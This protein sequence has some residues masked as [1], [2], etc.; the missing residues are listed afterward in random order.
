MAVKQ[1]VGARYVP[2]FA[3]PIEWQA[4]T[5][6]DALTIVLYNNASYTSKVTVPPTVGNPTE[7]TNY[8]ALTGNYNA[9]VEQYRQDIVSYK[10]D[11]DNQL[12]EVNTKIDT[13]ETN[14][15]T[16]LGE[17]NTKI[18]TLETNT[19]TQLGEVN[20]KI[21]TL[22][23][24]IN[25][26][27]SSLLT[28]LTSSFI[29][30]DASGKGDFTSIT[31]AMEASD[32]KVIKIFLM[33]GSYHECLDFTS[34][35]DVTIIGESKNA[36][37]YNDGGKYKYSTITLNQKFYLFNLTIKAF[38]NSTFTPTYDSS[39]VENTFPSYALHIDKLQNDGG[40]TGI[41]ENCVIQSSSGACVGSGTQQNS[42][43]KFID[44]EIN[45]DSPTSY[46]S[47]SPHYDSALLIHNSVPQSTIN[48][49]AYV[50]NCLVTNTTYPSASFRGDLPSSSEFTLH[51][52]NN[53]FELINSLSDGVYYA[54]SSSNL[55]G[56]N[57]NSYE[58]NNSISNHNYTK[59]YSIRLENGQHTF[60]D[61]DFENAKYISVDIRQDSDYQTHGGLTISMDEAKLKNYKNM[62]CMW[63]GYVYETTGACFMTVTLKENQ[64]V[65]TTNST[66]WDTIDLLLT[67]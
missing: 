33:N 3:T 2:K 20:T 18:D 19:D 14:T 67:Y 17:V 22:E 56:A 54:K 7:N 34:Y 59:L 64:I 11:T 21:D 58:L 12:G 23:T 43:L 46:L 55:L 26:V 6:Y 63:T 52:Y 49:H 42:N 31:Q 8:W 60:S 10:E 50:I 24:N 47:Y 28:K 13:L 32:K 5:S 36:I 40:Y 51:V 4:N 37:I 41:V 16:Q 57:N 30:V 35:D 62:N 48:Q 38:Y 61:I 53:T 44:C 1:Y 15:N 27:Q 45:R 39:D 29:T 65:V 9:Q 25:K 66:Q